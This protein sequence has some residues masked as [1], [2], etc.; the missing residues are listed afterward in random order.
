VDGIRSRESDQR[1]LNLIALP[2]VFRASE[3]GLSVD[4][5]NQRQFE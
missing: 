5:Q 1:F 4:E 3:P 2:Q